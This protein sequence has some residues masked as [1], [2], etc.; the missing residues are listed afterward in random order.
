MAGSSGAQ[1]STRMAGH[2]HHQKL[3]L[4]HPGMKRGALPRILRPQ[5]LRGLIV[6]VRRRGSRLRNV[7]FGLLG[8]I[9]NLPR[10][11]AVECRRGAQGE[12]LGPWLEESPRTGFLTPCIRT[13]A[14][15]ADMQKLF[16]AYP[17]LTPIDLPA[18]LSAWE[19]GFRCGVH[20]SE[21]RCCGTAS[22]SAE[23]VATR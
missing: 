19:S 8:E 13:Q 18:V 22:S 10:R 9:C 6:R 5:N 1:G 4:H 14:R 3:L 16:Q 2:C 15:I 21:T 17:F 7:L 23:Q 20:Q 11:M 12:Y